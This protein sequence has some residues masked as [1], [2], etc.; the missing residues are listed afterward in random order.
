MKNKDV[1]K[2]FNVASRNF[3]WT[4]VGNYKEISVRLFGVWAEVAIRQNPQYKSV[5][6]PPFLLAATGVEPFSSLRF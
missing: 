4:A 5:L 1:V 2:Y 6:E 3:L